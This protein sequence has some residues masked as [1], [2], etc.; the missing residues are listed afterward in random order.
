MAG[1]SEVTQLLLDH[2]ADVNVQMEENRRTALHMAALRGHVQVVEVLLKRGA[3][4]H[5]RSRLGQTPFQFASP[6]WPWGPSSPNNT[7]IL[8]LLSE[9]TG[10]KM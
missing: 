6:S 4:P 1:H 7:Q 8:R 5:A 10:E 9:H 3:D 2:G